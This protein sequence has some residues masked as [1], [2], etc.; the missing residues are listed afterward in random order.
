MPS[1]GVRSMV[2][3]ATW[4]HPADRGGEAMLII[5]LLLLHTLMEYSVRHGDLNAKRRG[6]HLVGEALR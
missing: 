4:I 3:G 6:L 1:D 2:G 5:Q